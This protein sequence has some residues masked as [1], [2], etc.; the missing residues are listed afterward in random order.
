LLL[1]LGAFIPLYVS[2]H[3]RLSLVAN[4]LPIIA[5]RVQTLAMAGLFVSIYLSIRLLPPKPPR[6]KTRHRFYMIVQWVYL[7]FT[8]IIFNSFAA[9]YSQTRLM[10]GWYIGKFDITEKAVKK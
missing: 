4:Q 6:Y 10:F 3:S 1:L 8:T 7:P 2:P 5:S 9:L